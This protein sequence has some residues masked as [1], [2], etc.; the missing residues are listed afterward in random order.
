MTVSYAYLQAFTS[1][2][3]ENRYVKD[4][5]TYI[6]APG[7][8]KRLDEWKLRHAADGIWMGDGEY[9]KIVVDLPVKTVYKAPH[10][11]PT[12]TPPSGGGSGGGGTKTPVLLYK[13]AW[14]AQS[15]RYGNG[16]EWYFQSMYSG[17][18]WHFK[19]YDEPHFVLS[20]APPCIYGW[21]DFSGANGYELLCVDPQTNY[22]HY[23]NWG[24]LHDGG[25]DGSEIRGWYFLHVIY[26]LQ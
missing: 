25:W 9:K 10:N 17:D 16:E 23:L 4:G 7:E 13:E 5:G 14:Q 18:V 6:P 2:T 26:K 11:P 19:V 15:S 8:R 20:W 24:S 1:D 21:T 12:P 22:W 3:F